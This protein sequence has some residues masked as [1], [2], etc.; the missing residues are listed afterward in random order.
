MNVIR[1]ADKAFTAT[2]RALTTQSSLFDPTIEERTRAILQDV[3]A[4]GDAALC[5]APGD[6]Q[7]DSEAAKTPPS[8]ADPST[9]QVT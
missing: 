5:H 2:I 8:T 9:S 4:R 7:A 1:H 6:R 3:Y